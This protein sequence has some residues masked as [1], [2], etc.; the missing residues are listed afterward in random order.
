MYDHSNHASAQGSRLHRGFFYKNFRRIMMRETAKKENKKGYTLY[1]QQRNKWAKGAQ[2]D[3][4]VS[5]LFF[6]LG[7][8][9]LLFNCER[10][11]IN[12]LIF[13]FV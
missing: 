13:F 8:I 10:N 1:M 2:L 11:K 7:E 6:E 9:V 12:T 5:T 4:T 3:F